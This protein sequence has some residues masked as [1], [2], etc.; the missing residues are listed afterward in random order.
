MVGIISGLF[1]K[2][3]KKKRMKSPTKMKCPNCKTRLKKNKTK[4][5]FYNLFC[6]NCDCYWNKVDVKRWQKS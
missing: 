2:K 5:R 6:K 3:R 4:H 1:K